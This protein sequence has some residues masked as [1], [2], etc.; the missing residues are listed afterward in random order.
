MRPTFAIL[1][2]LALG[3]FAAGKPDRIDP[4]EEKPAPPLPANVIEAWKNAGAEVIWK[5][6]APF[7]NGQYH[8][9]KQDKRKDLTVFNFQK[10]E[11]GMLDS[12]PV[13]EQPF[14]LAFNGSAVSVAKLNELARFKTLSDLSLFS[15]GLAD[16]DLK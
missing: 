1:L 13:P 6:R 8:D 15:T 4:T 10:W 5:E 2:L 11:A 7:G 3:A 14:G 16:D 9:G 12:L